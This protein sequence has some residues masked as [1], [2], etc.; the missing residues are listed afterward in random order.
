MYINSRGFKVWN[1]ISILK[2][3][4][5]FVSNFKQSSKQFLY[6]NTETKLN[7]AYCIISMPIATWKGDLIVCY[8]GR[9]CCG[10]K[11]IFKWE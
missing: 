6:T 7:I 5:V 3:A 4:N 9:Y 10:N 2:E 11:W 8:P 1:A